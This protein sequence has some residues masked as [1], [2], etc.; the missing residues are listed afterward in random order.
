MRKPAQEAI[1]DGVVELR[2][3]EAGAIG[4][5]ANLLLVVPALGEFAGRVK[6]VEGSIFTGPAHTE[7]SRGEGIERLMEV[8]AL[9]A[10]CCTRRRP[11]D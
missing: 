9:V 6:P 5:Q 10:G 2:R 7:G 3:H 1:Q 8:G 11:R 4:C